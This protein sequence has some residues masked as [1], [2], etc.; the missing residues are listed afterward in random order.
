VKTD[1]NFGGQP[2]CRLGRRW[3]SLVGRLWRRAAPVAERA[4]GRHLAW[5]RVLRAY[6]IYGSLAEVP[7]GVFRNRALVVERFLPE[8]DGDQYVVRYLLCLGDRLRNVRVTAPTPIVKAPSRGVA[9][10]VGPVPEAVLRL[11][12]RLGL[13]YGKIDYTL[14]DGEVVILDVNRTLGRTG[15]PE[16]RARSVSILADGIWS[17][18]PGG[19]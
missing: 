18:L 3:P 5:Q 16:A 17:L 4:L 1:D 7:A 19:R 12:G 14:R 6:P 15:T 13:D 10:E 8:R 2:E 9:E 11:R